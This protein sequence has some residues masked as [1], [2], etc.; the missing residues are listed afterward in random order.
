[1][2]SLFSLKLGQALLFP[3]LLSACATP[4]DAAV[5]TQSIMDQQYDATGASAAIPA[6]EA[7]IIQKKYEEKIGQPL[8]ASKT[9]RVTDF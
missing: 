6:R 8:P 7:V 3:V 9:G 4:P 5:R 2:K 1:M